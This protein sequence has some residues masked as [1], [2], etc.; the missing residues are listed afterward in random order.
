MASP[1]VFAGVFA[2]LFAA[3]EV[4]DHWVQ[5]HTQAVRKGSPGW[6]GRLACARHVATYTATLTVVL[7]LVSWRLGI[8]YSLPN[9]VAAVVLTAG[10]HYWADRR[11]TLRRLAD[12]ARK[13]DFA[14]LGDPLAAPTGTGAYSL[15]QA[16][17]IGFLSV[18]ALILA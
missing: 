14:G 7:A 2:A 16:W 4:A 13:G 9:V 17:H 5:T 1:E 18:A 10:T 3:H 6:V 8:G 12:L 11:T 15:D